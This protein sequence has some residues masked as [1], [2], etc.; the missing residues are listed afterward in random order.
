M[1]RLA[2]RQM[3]PEKQRGDRG[4]VFTGYAGVDRRIVNRNAIEFGQ[5][6]NSLVLTSCDP[7]ELEV[8]VR[9]ADLR[10]IAGEAVPS[11]TKSLGGCSGAPLMVVS[12]RPDR[13]FWFG[14]V[15]IKQV[16]AADEQDFTTLIAGGPPA[17]TKTGRWLRRATSDPPMRPALAIALIVTPGPRIHPLA[18]VGR[19]RRR[20]KNRSCR[21]ARNGSWRWKECCNGLA[22]ISIP[23]RVA[24]GGCRVTRLPLP[25]ATA[26]VAQNILRRTPPI[27]MMFHLRSFA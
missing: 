15:V 11:V 22:A 14:G 17:S 24:A 3:P 23:V 20:L 12:A 2:G 27:V 18:N 7:N 4:V 26:K 19:W 21:R 13:L 1:L 6:S 9:R 25:Y 10:P 5:T 16:L 8:Q